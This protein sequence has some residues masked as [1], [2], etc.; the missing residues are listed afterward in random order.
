MLTRK[1]TYKFHYLWIMWNSLPFSEIHKSELPT[2]DLGPGSFVLKL[3]HTVTYVS[4]LSI[5]LLSEMEA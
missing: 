3:V 2:L 4:S 5:S 1:I